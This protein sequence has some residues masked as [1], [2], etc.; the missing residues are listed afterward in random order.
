MEYLDK[1]KHDIAWMNYYDLL[2][3]QEV[4]NKEIESHKLCVIRWKQ[5]H[6]KEVKKY[7]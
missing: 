1:F 6:E 2:K 4:I 3:V 7:V 5:I